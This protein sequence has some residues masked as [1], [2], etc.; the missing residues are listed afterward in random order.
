[1]GVF[2]KYLTEK[3]LKMG[4]LLPAFR[5]SITGVGAGPSMFEITALLGKEETIARINKALQKIK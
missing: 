5:L 2:E 1:M 4:E 3:S